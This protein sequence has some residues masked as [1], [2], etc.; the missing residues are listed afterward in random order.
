MQIPKLHPIVYILSG[1][2]ILLGLFISFAFLMRENW[3]VGIDAAWGLSF[4]C[5]LLLTAITLIVALVFGIIH[6][7]KKFKKNK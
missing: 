5:L 6:I 7:Y 1:E 4:I 3:D 2:I